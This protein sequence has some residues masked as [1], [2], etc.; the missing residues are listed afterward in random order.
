MTN[1]K[2]K[3]AFALLLGTSWSTSAL[4]QAPVDA[5]AQVVIP[6]DN[7][8]PAPSPFGQKTTIPNP[9]ADVGATPTDTPRNLSGLESQHEKTTPTPKQMFGPA[10]TTAIGEMPYNAYQTQFINPNN[11]GS[12]NKIPDTS[13]NNS[14]PVMLNQQANQET[15]TKYKTGVENLGKSAVTVSQNMTSNVTLSNSVASVYVAD[16]NI[17]TVHPASDHR[18]VIFGVKTGQ[19]AITAVDSNGNPIAHFIV[20]VVPSGYAAQQAEASMPTGAI[21]KEIPGAIKLSGTVA[22]PLDAVNADQTAKAATVGTNDTVLNGLNVEQP[23]QVMLQVKIAQMSRSVT[24]Q[25]GINWQSIGSLGQA[26]LLM[27]TTSGASAARSAV[28]IGANSL[29]FNSSGNL[30]GAGSAGNYTLQ[31]GHTSINAVLSMLDSD[32]LAH[33]LAEPTLMALSGHTASFQSG[34]SFPVPIPG[35]N[36]Q[37]SVEFQNYGVQLKFRPIVLSSGQIYLDVEPTVSQ[38]SNLNSVTVGAGSSAL[39]VPSLVQQTASTTVMLGSGQTLAI[40]GL[41]EDQ[42]NQS[43][44]GVPGLS[45]VPIFGGAFKSD[46]YQRAEQ[47]LVIL[48]TPYI[49]TPQSNPNMLHVAGQDWTPPNLVQRY[50]LGR[51]IGSPPQMETLPQGVGFLLK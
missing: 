46:F 33:I 12:S 9:G 31:F 34:G 22:T 32:S 48:V 27:G 14:S 10:G 42:T 3:I 44:T 19:T 37:D 23:Q 36:G 45:N 43:D 49:V 20:T 35:Q 1:K 7:A 30:I 13:D 26:G 38:V 15:E 8:V 50:L 25:L 41:L 6:S 16:P 28:Q 40:A 18:L 21:A 11:V 17:I 2:L 47:E 5:N 51:Q 39:V 4:A 29:G 24:Q